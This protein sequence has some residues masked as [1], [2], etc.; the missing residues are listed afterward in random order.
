MVQELVLKRR[1]VDLDSDYPLLLAMQRLSWRINFPGTLFQEAAFLASL[2]AGHRRDL[3]YVYEME[4][5]I[6]GWLWLDSTSRNRVHI[7]H[8][9]VRQSRWGQGLGRYLMEDAIRLCRRLGCR[10][11]TLNVT[12]AN[13]RAMALYEH[14]GFDITED[15]G[16]R[17]RMRL[18][19][20]VFAENQPER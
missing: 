18:D 6:V 8:I 12:K 15:Y 10:T 9:Q 17:Q 13:E 20:T 19:L 14:L 2:H 5:E 4:G 1:P 16:E 7:R 11:L 3:I